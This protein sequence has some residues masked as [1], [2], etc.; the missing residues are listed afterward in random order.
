[1]SGRGTPEYLAAHLQEALARDPR[2]NEPELQ[3]SIVAGRVRIT[4]VVPTEE[5]RAAVDEVAAERC[6]DL[7]VE[8][9]TTVGRYPDA[10]REERVT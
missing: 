7:E 2:V 6:A 8:N 1:M 10:E 3:V 5:R 4:G 9:R